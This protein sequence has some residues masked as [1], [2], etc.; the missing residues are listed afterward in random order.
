[1]NDKKF[2]KIVRNK[3]KEEINVP[4]TLENNIFKTLNVECKEPQTIRLKNRFTKIVQTIV[5]L[6][7]IAAISGAVYA[8]ATGKIKFKQTGVQGIL[9]SYEENAIEKVE[10]NETIDG[11]NAI[12]TLKNIASDGNMVILEYEIELKD[13]L[14]EM[15]FRKD[16]NHK[17]D[18]IELLDNPT[19]N[20]FTEL[21]IIANSYEELSP[22]VFK[23]LEIINIAE[24]NGENIKISRPIKLVKVDGKEIPIDNSEIPLIDENFSEEDLKEYNF[25]PEDRFLINIDIE[26]RQDKEG[27]QE[28]DIPDGK[29]KIE[30]AVNT[31][32][33]IVAYGNIEINNIKTGQES[34]TEIYFESDEFDEI[35]EY[36][37]KSQI[38]TENDEVIE[39]TYEKFNNNIV[40]KDVPTITSEPNV[41]KLWTDDWGTI[42][43]Y[44]N[45]KANIK[46]MMLIPGTE[47][48]IGNITL[49]AKRNY[50][51]FE[52]PLSINLRKG[53]AKVKVKEI[54]KKV[55]QSDSYFYKDDNVAED[56]KNPYYNAEAPIIDLQNFTIDQLKLGMNFPKAM[57]ELEQYYAER[58]KK[59]EVKEIGNELEFNT[60]E[61]FDLNDNTI[62]GV[63]Y[64]NGNKI[65][66]MDKE[67]ELSFRSEEN[68]DQEYDINSY[69]LTNLSIS[70]P[71]DQDGNQYRAK[72]FVEN[73]YS[74]EFLKVEKTNT[75]RSKFLYGE[76]KNE[77]DSY[78][79]ITEMNNTDISIQYY[80]GNSKMSLELWLEK[81]TKKV[82]KL[83]LK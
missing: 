74:N 27:M 65:E 25:L 40:T 67:H 18:K 28:Y 57:K 69:I 37:L 20:G 14:F 41:G 68:E 10:I 75:G 72:T 15:W 79:L 11:N 48:N 59:L 21:E 9:E 61:E 76:S 52:K 60:L 83:E 55:D 71:K 34:L 38:E 78:A 7:S 63:Y 26:N 82:T 8:G 36:L 33:G 13:K 44:Q 80:D 77:E 49:K 12:T 24:I 47:N 58:N 35:R 5:A 19:V 46:Y 64:Q 50:D 70:N 2:D 54:Y 45:G 4:N 81:G 22:R 23:Y 1:M 39:L 3:I 30:S 31:D 16:Q 66:Y 42:G 32:L 29:I 73:F 51:N 56:I 17:V 6:L 62:V 43:D 53:T